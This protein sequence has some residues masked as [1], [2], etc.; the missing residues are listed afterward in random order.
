MK[1]DLLSIVA[2]VEQCP[3][4]RLARGLGYR[5]LAVD[6]N[7]HACG[8][9]EADMGLVQDPADVEALTALARR[10]GVRAL[11][12]VPVGALLKVAGEVNDR[13]ALPGISAAGA[14]ASTDKWLQRSILRAAGLSQ[15]ECYLAVGEAE[16]RAAVASVGFPAIVKPRLG[17]GS[18][19]V[20]RCDD[21]T[22]FDRL[23]P[24]HLDAIS[25]QAKAATLVE[26][27]AQGDEFGVDAVVIDG[28]FELLAVRQKEMTPPPF[29]LGFGY[30]SPPEV[31]EAMLAHIA[32]VC[33]ASAS[34]LGLDHCLLHADVMASQDNE[35]TIIE[36]SG[37]PSGF[38]LSALMLPA[39]V[40]FSPVEEMI[41]WLMTGSA[42]FKPRHQRAAVL[43]MLSCGQG[44]IAGIDGIQAALQ[45]P[46]V[47]GVETFVKPGDRIG[48]R[49]SGATAYKLG[50]LVTSGKTLDKAKETWEKAN[51]VIRF[52]LADTTDRQP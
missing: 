22:D 15:P 27:C 47:V 40:G 45:M 6:R 49:D 18:S 19:G 35:A 10:A 23:L 3:A 39:L 5:V 44:T 4:I 46:D 32:N 25:T 43:R 36:M 28:N 12:P 9:A 16:I 17:S 7:P 21:W 2:G 31:S 29:R 50:Y 24:W 37:R 52:E 33:A 42:N 26:S 48:R 20:F 30:S 8:L 14:E 38:N 13:L 34:A 1:A 11:L 51:A 41:R